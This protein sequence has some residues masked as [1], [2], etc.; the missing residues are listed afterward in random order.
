MA[1]SRYKYLYERL[2]DHQFQLLVNALLAQ[3]YDDYVP[4]PLRQ[5]DGGRDGLRGGNE[6]RLA[7]QVKW[8]V[9]G[10]EKD[11]VKWLDAV[12]RGEEDN[13]KRL[14]QSGVRK[15]VLVTNVPS[16]GR[17][18][19][20]TNDRLNVRLADLAAKWGFEAMECL[21]RETV[22]AMVDGAPAEVKWAYADMLVGWDLVRYLSAEDQAGRRD[23]ALRKLIR[24]A[25]MAQWDADERVKFSQVEINRERVADLFVD[26]HA[27][28]LGGRRDSVT[29]RIASDEPINGAADYLLRRAGR[30]TLVRGAPG[31]GK[32]TLA[33]YVAQV[34]RANFVPA[35]LRPAALVH[36]S[37]SFPIRLDLS[38][39]SRWLEGFDVWGPDDR[40]KP[41]R[42][43]AAKASME[44][45]IADFLSH[46]AG[47]D[48]VDVRRVNEIFDLVPCVVILD[49]LDEVGKLQARARVVSEIDRF[50]VRGRAIEG[51]RIVVTTRPS[52]NALPEPSAEIFDVIV[53]KPFEPKQREDYLR[54]WTKVHGL[55]G[56]EGRALRKVYNARIREPFLADLAGN[57][58]QLT[59][60]LDLLHRNGEATPTQRTALYDGYVGLLL[61]REANKHPNSVRDHQDDLREIIPFLGWHLHAHTEVDVVNTRMSV[62]DLK[63]SMLHFL[64]T[65]AKSE[66][67]VDDLFEATSDRLWT[68]TSKTQGTYE[69]EVLPLRE[70]FA[71]RFLYHWAGEDLDDFDQLEVL[72]EL[73]RRPYWLNTTRFYGGNAPVPGVSNL[74]DGVLAAVRGEKNVATIVAAWTL[75][76]DGVF[77]RR[78]LR[79][80]EITAELA[81]DRYLAI[82]NQAWARREL[83]AMPRPA[84]SASSAGAAPVPVSGADPA[85]DK[86]TGS[87]AA[88]PDDP[89]TG[90]RVKLLTG[91]L[92]RGAAFAHWWADQIE[93]RHHAGQ[94][95]DAWIRMPPRDGAFYVNVD[96]EGLDLR[97]PGVTR[98]FLNTGASPTPGGLF[99][100]ALLASVLDG[101]CPD[102]PEPRSLPAMVA[103][104]FGAANMIA[105][106]SN[107]FDADADTVHARMRQKAL[108]GL[109]QHHPALSAAARERRFAAGEADSTFPWTRTATAL[110]DA[111]GPCWLASQIAII[112]AASPLGN[113]VRKLPGVPA[114]GPEDHPA[115]LLNETRENEGSARWW[116]DQLDDLTGLRAADAS[117]ANL[118]RY[119][120][121]WVGAAWCIADPLVLAEIFEV[122]STAFAGLSEFRTAAVT[123]LI[124]VCT[125]SRWLHPL[126]TSITTANPRIGRL[127]TSR[128][129]EVGMPLAKPRRPARPSSTPMT[130]LRA[131]KKA[132]STPAPVPNRASLG[133]RSVAS[134][135]APGGDVPMTLLTVARDRKWFKVDRGG[136]YR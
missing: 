106:T 9:Q 57:P 46:A 34:H 18:G 20:G 109:R 122:W 12:V 31:Q 29:G 21:W 4:M 128:G 85:W 107:S 102:F 129:N 58:M 95:V 32:S 56:R 104:A 70:Y 124:D 26:V 121:E 74:A 110:Y 100:A 117:N 41:R 45:F 28:R 10:R 89:L 24:T 115:S 127:L 67:V 60:L 38:E 33:Q 5:A 126:D 55:D 79:A 105:V 77:N 35:E 3:R 52:S 72:H 136:H 16:T 134:A 64:R 88:A 71:A 61:A 92:N 62:E 81:S 94:Q 103:V 8:S 119:L 54:K 76:T 135:V 36:G 114:F 78:P 59:I 7:Y 132:T 68:L 48:E 63:A 123:H 27:V 43:P 125:S 47:G 73:M 11:P 65:Y 116:L 131:A 17:Q 82:L 13:L 133:L 112:G 113:G 83:N 66:V 44:W 111:V 53:L 98:N 25:A 80:D 40:A 99:E 84:V 23:T 93:E 108:K 130:P 30:C 97:A 37:P 90:D 2:T 91:P 49:G 101:G 51:H 15:Y 1:E 87:L 6:R 14:A 86:L 120:G 42:R 69:F 118:D 22:D 96:L 50:A 19:S 39:Y 75:L